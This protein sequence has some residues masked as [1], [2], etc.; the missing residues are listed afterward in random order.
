[1]ADFSNLPNFHLKLVFVIHFMLISLACIGYWAPSSYLFY[2]FVLIIVLLWAIHK[3]DS[4]EPLQL[5]IFING[6]SVILDIII[7]S[8]RFPDSHA[9]SERFSAALS[10]IHLII[11]PFTTIFLVK[12]LQERSPTPGSGIANLFTGARNRSYEDMDKNTGPQLPPP[13]S[14]QGYDFTTAQQI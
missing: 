7:I 6:M 12:L 1:M 13:T 2:N 4:D 8:M 10:I 5:C 11:R 3:N 9:G 14:S